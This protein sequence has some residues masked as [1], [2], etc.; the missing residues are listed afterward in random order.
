MDINNTNVIKDKIAGSGLAA[1]QD[2]GSGDVIIRLSSPY[3]LIV[4]KEALENVCSFCL[5]EASSVDTPL[6]RCSACKVPRYCSS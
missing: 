5:I 6:K 4:E 1:S 2:I 3:L